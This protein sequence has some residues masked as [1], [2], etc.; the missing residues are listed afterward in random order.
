MTNT[1]GR[2]LGDADLMAT[3]KLEW[4]PERKTHRGLIAS[5]WNNSSG[6]GRRISMEVLEDG[7]FSDSK[8]KS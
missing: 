7:A 4:G 6:R 2:A 3:L 5:S 8:A 1:V